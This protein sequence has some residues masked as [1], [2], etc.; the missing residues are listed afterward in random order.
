M[1]LDRRESVTRIFNAYA[2]FVATNDVEA[3][4]RRVNDVFSQ[5]EMP[6]EELTAAVEGI[7]AAEREA[8]EKGWVMQ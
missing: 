5:T 1:S 8:T 6:K 7:L 2:E 4:M 3:W